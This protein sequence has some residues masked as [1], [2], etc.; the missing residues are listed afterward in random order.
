MFSLSVYRWEMGDVIFWARDVG[1][2]PRRENLCFK[3]LALYPNASLLSVGAIN[4][5]RDI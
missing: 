2:T 5:R 3:P 4:F 1:S